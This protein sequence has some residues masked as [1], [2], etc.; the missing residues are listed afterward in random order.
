MSIRAQGASI[1]VGLTTLGIVLVSGLEAKGSSIS[2]T[3][4]QR[5]G[6]E[7]TFNYQYVFD[8]TLQSNSSIQNGDSFT[9][10]SLIGITPP[11]FPLLGDGGSTSSEPNGNWSPLIGLTTSSF[12]Y[13]SDVT[14]TYGGSPIST[15]SSSL[16]LGQFIVDTAVNLQSQPYTNGTVIDFTYS[17]GGQSVSG[18]GSFSMSVSVPEPTSLIMLVTGAS[19]VLLLLPNCRRC[20]SRLLAA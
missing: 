8:V 16:D 7:D 10:D 9:I 14:W 12:P 17:I 2:I 6:T 20:L 11:N 19:V 3:G 1:L 18:S 15:G 4:Q 5:P 13:T